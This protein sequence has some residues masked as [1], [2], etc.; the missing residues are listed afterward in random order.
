MLGTP[1]RKGYPLAKGLVYYGLM[2]EGTGT[3]VFD[4]IHGNNGTLEGTSPS[5]VPGKFGS[6]I[7]LPDTGSEFISVP[8]A[9]IFD[10]GAGLT[11]SIWFYTSENQT[12]QG[13]LLHDLSSFKYMIYLTSGSGQIQFYADISTVKSCT[14]GDLGNGYFANRWINVVGTYDGSALRIYVDGVLMGTTGGLSGTIDAGDEG[15]SFGKYGV[16]YFNGILDLPMIWNCALNASGIQSLFYDPFC[17][18]GRMPIHKWA[19][20]YGGAGPS[21]TLLDYERRTRGANRGVIR[22]AA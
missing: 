21:Q 9:D 16:N 10:V 20:A 14:T 11:C 12:G 13:I 15:I 7:N 2:N 4:L 8:D 18:F 17:M 19:G 5:W 1:L 22:G 3:K 6:A